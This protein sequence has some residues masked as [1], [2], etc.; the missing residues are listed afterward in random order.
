MNSV[1]SDYNIYLS[2]VDFLTVQLIMNKGFLV[3]PLSMEVDV[4]KIV[5]DNIVNFY[6]DNLRF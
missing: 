1:S 4:L 2:N 5:F 6:K 3:I